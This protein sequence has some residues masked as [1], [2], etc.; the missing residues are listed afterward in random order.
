MMFHPTPL[1]GA[2]VL[3]LERREDARGFFARAFCVRELQAHGLAL[4]VAQINVAFTRRRGTVRGLHYQEPPATETKLV[5][6]T[7]GGVLDVIVDLRPGSPTRLRH[8][9]VEL[10][11]A[12]HRALLVPPLCAHGYQTLTDDAEITYLVSEFYAPAQER[13]L[14]HDDP[15]LAI[16]WPL[17]VADVSDKDAAWPLL[18]VQAVASMEAS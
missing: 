11:A 4:A 12:N 10:T 9:A 18:D 7:Q 13:G 8:A 17:P 2:F 16:R 14:R 15:A 3:D 5:R 1:A 6:C